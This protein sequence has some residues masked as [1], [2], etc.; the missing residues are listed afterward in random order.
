MASVTDLTNLGEVVSTDVLIIGAGIAGLQ[1]AIKARVTRPVSVLVVDKATPGYAGQGPRLGGHSGAVPEH[2]LDSWLKGKVEEGGYLNDQELTYTFGKEMIKAHEE[3]FDWGAP[4]LKDAQGKL[5]IEQYDDTDPDSPYRAVWI[6]PPAMMQFLK[7]KARSAG[8]NI[9]KRTMV[10]ELLTEGERVVGAVGFSIDNGQFYILKA[11]A[12]IIAN[13]ACMYR[14]RSLFQNNSG[15]GVAAAYNVGAEMRNAEF[16]NTVSCCT[17]D[18]LRGAHG[19]YRPA[20]NALGENIG[21]KYGI[22]EWAKG[23]YHVMFPLLWKEINEGRGPVYSTEGLRV[24]DQPEHGRAV[25]STRKHGVKVREKLGH[26]PDQKQEMVLAQS[27]RQGP[28]KIDLR[29]RATLPGLWAVG[30][31]SFG[32]SGYCGAQGPVMAVGGQGAGFAQITGHIAGLDAAEFASEA[33]APE[34]DSSQVSRLKEQIYAP[35]NR[36]QGFDPN[37]A[38]YQVQEAIMSVKY[39]IYKSGERMQEA[40]AKVEKVKGILPTL[41]AK[42]LHYLVK[43]HEAASMTLCAEMT[44]VPGLIR[45]ESRSTFIREDYPERDDENWLKWIMIKK[46]NEEMKMWTEPVPIDK[47]KIKP[48]K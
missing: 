6:D 3:A 25:V 37:D 10:T 40:L 28:I 8:V 15:V 21:D 27:N 9:L 4:Y 46:E 26:A 45:K 2:Q 43:A 14:Y 42:D 11:K 30:D 16:A 13:G 29:C 33:A 44:Y 7:A 35:L 1:A 41:W 48:P 34:I 36:K 12:T 38:I 32:G 23:H 18:G 20:E 47:Y 39:N 19:S 24:L 22:P 5:V 17:K 31:A